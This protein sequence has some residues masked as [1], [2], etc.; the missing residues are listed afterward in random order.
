MPFSGYG[1]NLGHSLAYGYTSYITGYL[2]ANYP[3]EFFCACLNVE[4]ERKNHDKILVF[5]RDAKN[6]GIKFLPK[7]VNTACVKYKIIKK[8]DEQ[9]GILQTEMSPSL[10]VKGVG[11]PSAEEIEKHKPYASFRDLACKT[12]SRLVDQEVI[13]ALIDEG[14]FDSMLSKKEDK[15]A[16]NKKTKWTKEELLKM[17][18]DYREDMIKAAKRGLSSA[19]IFE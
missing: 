10:M 1:F 12:D 16:G 7:Q 18:S 17:F 6:F 8:K 9:N 2:K 15:K 19:D 3:E 11:K 4:N 13:G 14:F 5:A